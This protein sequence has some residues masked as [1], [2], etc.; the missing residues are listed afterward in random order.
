MIGHVSLPL[1]RPL[2][3]GRP[4]TSLRPAEPAAAEPWSIRLW[5]N[6]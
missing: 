5:P 4:T 1:I 6:R 2:F 3:C